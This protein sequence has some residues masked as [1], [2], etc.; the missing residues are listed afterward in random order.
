MGDISGALEAVTL[1]L[2]AIPSSQAALE[3]YNAVK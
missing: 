1:A 2:S 3:I